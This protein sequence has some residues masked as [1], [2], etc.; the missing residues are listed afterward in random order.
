VPRQKCESYKVF[1]KNLERSRAFLRLFDV[2][3]T[4]GQPSNDEKELLRGAI[5]FA[6]GAL[7]AF[8]HE[9]V[10]EVV[11]KF[12]GNRQALADALR[13][14]AKDDPGL[15]L[16]LAL[17]PDGSSKEDEF[18]AALDD[19]L[20]KKSFQGVARVSNALTYVGVNLTIGDFDQHTGVNTAERL[21]HYTKM[22][23]NIVHRG[24]KPALVRNNAQE[25]VDVISKMG[26]AINSEAIG[27]YSNA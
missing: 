19:W 7:D 10:L 4:A 23:H 2:D 18:R 27:F 14:I 26:T 1:E 13:A 15:S 12:G 16:R 11:P 5:V 24:A 22:R 8:L 21:E 20:E 6:I 17:A 9:L 25:C 3:R